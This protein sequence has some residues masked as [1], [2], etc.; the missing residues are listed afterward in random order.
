MITPL[1]STP[2][3]ETRKRSEYDR[4]PEYQMDYARSLQ[5]RGLTFTEISRRIQYPRAAVVRSLYYDRYHVDRA[6]KKR[7]GWVLRGTVVGFNTP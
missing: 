1:P 5:R 7:G 4:I 6:R 2:S 3:R